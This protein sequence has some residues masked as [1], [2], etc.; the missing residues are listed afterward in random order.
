[1]A[2]KLGLILYSQFSVLRLLSSKNSLSPIKVK[3]FNIIL[4]KKG[5]QTPQE[6]E[7]D[8]N[9][10][11]IKQRKLW[12]WKLNNYQY[13]LT[14]RIN[15]IHVD[16]EGKRPDPKGHILCGSNYMGPQNRTYFKNRQNQP[17]MIEVGIVV[18]FEG[19]QRLRGGLRAPSGVMETF[20]ILI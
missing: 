5:Q 8:T 20:Y 15:L 17:P 6:I 12:Q 9:R 1:M 14:T 7:L 11:V 16:A 3:I 18:I 19:G 4:A 10:R 13:T 2:C